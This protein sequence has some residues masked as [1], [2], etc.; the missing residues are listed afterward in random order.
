MLTE[1]ERRTL[2]TLARE[3]ITQAV[4][5]HPLP[6][7]P[8]EQMT[9]RL[10]APGAS[11]VTLHTKAGALRGCIGSLS[12]YR[13]LVEDVQ[14]N[15]LA[16]AFRDPRFLPVTARELPNLEIEVSVLSEP[17]P[18]VFDGPEDLVRKLRPGVDGVVLQKGWHRAT[19][20]PQ[21]WEQLPSPE[22]FLEQLC[23]KAG[24]PKDAWRFPGVEVEIYQ[25][26]KFAEA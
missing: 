23:Y 26:E 7:V 25:V 19:F 6:T 4:Y 14:S 5:D 8:A 3:T 9:E 11:F 22:T 1:R 16:A 21:V 2:L 15:A 12:A 10:R 13:P 18:L 17:Q 20:L 24:L